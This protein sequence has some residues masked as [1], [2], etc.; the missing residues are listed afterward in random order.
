MRY[1]ADASSAV[2]SDEA[3]VPETVGTTRPACIFQAEDGI[4]YR[5]VARVQTCA[6]PLLSP[7][8]GGL[9]RYPLKTV[10]PIAFFLLGLQG[11]SEII[12]RLAIIR[13]MSPEAVGLKETLAIE[14]NEA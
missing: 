8:P 14:E 1:A 11:I 4:R 6:L 13:G 12:K 7:D 9:P 2:W 10:V 5:L 3:Y